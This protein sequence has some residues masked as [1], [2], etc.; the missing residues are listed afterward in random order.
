MG[1][2]GK[3]KGEGCISHGK[4]K[5]TGES[6]K[7][8]GTVWR[9]SQHLYTWQFCGTCDFCGQACHS[10]SFAVEWQSN[11]GELIPRVISVFLLHEG[12]ACRHK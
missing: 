4:G 3:D 2:I 10:I 7:G 1:G 11:E 12:R 5:G 8:K 9:A 6:E